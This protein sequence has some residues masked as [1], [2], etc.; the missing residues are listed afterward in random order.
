ME[1]PKDAMTVVTYKTTDVEFHVGAYHMSRLIPCHDLC[2]QDMTKLQ[3]EFN[4]SRHV[5]DLTHLC[6]ECTGVLNKAWLH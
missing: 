3:N 6:N 5:Q 4:R 2:I 1:G